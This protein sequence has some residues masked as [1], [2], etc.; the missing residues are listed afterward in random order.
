M[1]ALR[2]FSRFV[3]ASL[4]QVTRG[5]PLY[6]TW[7]AG[8]AALLPAGCSPIIVTDAGFKGPWFKQVRDSLRAA[9]RAKQKAD[10]E[11]Q[12]EQFFAAQAQKAA[13]AKDRRCS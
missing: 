12:L 13:D 2:S 1:T 6:W 5:G 10:I 11:K 9:N 3:S 4:R 8:L 7:I